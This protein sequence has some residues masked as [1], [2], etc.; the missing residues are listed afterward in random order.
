MGSRRRG[1]TVTDVTDGV[2]NSILCGEDAGRPARYQARGPRPDL[3]GALGGPWAS[4]DNRFYSNG[5]DPC[6]QVA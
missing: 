5:R 1:R 2:S 6:S 3:D 4:P